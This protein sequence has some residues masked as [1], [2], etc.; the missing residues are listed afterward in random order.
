MNTNYNLNALDGYQEDAG[1][2]LTIGKNSSGE[3]ILVL[4]DKEADKVSSQALM[5]FAMHL[6]QSEQSDLTKIQLLIKLA[7][8]VKDIRSDELGKGV[9]LEE[10]SV[11]QIVHTLA[12]R[13]LSHILKKSD[14]GAAELAMA[15]K[16]DIKTDLEA[17]HKE[18]AVESAK[19]CLEAIEKCNPIKGPYL[20][21]VDGHFETTTDP[22]KQISSK[23]LLDHTE[24]LLTDLDDETVLDLTGSVSSYVMQKE[25]APDADFITLVHENSDVDRAHKLATYFQDKGI[26]Q[27]SMDANLK[28]AIRGAHKTLDTIDE[29]NKSKSDSPPLLAV[30]DD[31][32]WTTTNSKHVASPEDI[33]RIL[34]ACI[35]NTTTNRN[36]QPRL[37]AFKEKLF[38]PSPTSP[39]DITSSGSGT[40][41]SPG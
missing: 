31:A 34:D 36:E 17:L 7:H 19:E 12:L 15:E 1:K 2:Y 29:Y 24:R 39:G 20:A 13:Q 37:V 16:T 5:M 18:V 21:L 30:Y 38:P 23:D 9:D 14:E 35:P 6:A 3:Q 40:P 22:S 28:I 27:R 26:E 8:A 41:T 4:T 33:M 10:D 32:L 25:V 11:V